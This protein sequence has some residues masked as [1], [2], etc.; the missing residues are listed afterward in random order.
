MQC[1]P[2]MHHYANKHWRCPD[3]KKVNDNR[4]LK[5]D[6]STNSSAIF[7]R[8]LVNSDFFPTAAKFLD[9]SRFWAKVVTRLSAQK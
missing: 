4:F 3:N 2:K 9:I 1:M 8:L 5:Q 7:S 6:F